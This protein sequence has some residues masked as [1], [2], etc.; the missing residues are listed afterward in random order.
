V[1][2]LVIA[3]MSLL[4]IGNRQRLFA[5]LLPVIC[6]TME[7]VVCASSRFMQAMPVG[8]DTLINSVI[9]FT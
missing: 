7:L 2:A 8:V 4:L 9:S 1:R 3:I 6:Q 5:G